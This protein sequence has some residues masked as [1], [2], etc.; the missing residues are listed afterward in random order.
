MEGV[1]KIPLVGIIPTIELRRYCQ[2]YFV[3]YD[4]IGKELVMA[5][6]SEESAR[7]VA[8]QALIGMPFFDRIPVVPRG[9]PYPRPWLAYPAS[10]YYVD[11]RVMTRLA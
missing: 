6:T 5:F 2:A 9:T 7:D 3:V 1:E 11:P 4:S 10:F 8:N